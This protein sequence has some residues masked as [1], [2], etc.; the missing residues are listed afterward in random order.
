MGRCI[1][2]EARDHERK[3]SFT[4][5]AP[6]EISTLC[7]WISRIDNNAWKPCKR[8]PVEKHRDGSG[9]RVI[10]KRPDTTHKKVHVFDLIDHEG[11][12]HKIP[13]LKQVIADI[14]KYKNDA[15]ISELIMGIAEAE[16]KNTL[17]IVVDRE[18]KQERWAETVHDVYYLADPQQSISFEEACAHRIVY[19]IKKLNSLLFK[20]AYDTHYSKHQL[21]ELMINKISQLSGSLSYNDTL[22]LNTLLMRR[23]FTLEQ[24]NNRDTL[25]TNAEIKKLAAMPKD[26]YKVAARCGFIT[27]D[28]PKKLLQIAWEG[29]S[30]NTS[31]LLIGG[32]I[33]KPRTIITEAPL[34]TPY[35]ATVQ[36]ANSIGDNCVVS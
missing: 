12:Q 1:E 14:P 33:V 4:A 13:L 27:H 10:E 32:M 8:T 11:Y 19:E 9:F 22:F 15:P 30:P 35:T 29:G 3:F 31:L 24:A 17:S 20:E 2:A 36:L 34:L 25:L 16:S 5:Q 7:P 18:H 6:S 26:A 28:D 21:H 23:D